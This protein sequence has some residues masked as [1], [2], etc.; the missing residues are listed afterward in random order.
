VLGVLAFGILAT[1]L[2]PLWL[3]LKLSTFSAGF[4]FFCLFPLSVN[5][6]EYRL[7]VSPTKRLLWNIPTHG[8]W[9]IKYIQAEG[10]RVASTATPAPTALPLKTD[11]EGAAQ[12]DYGFYNAHFEK[13]SGHL[14]ISTDSLR[15]VS[16]HPKV[17]HFTLPYDQIH[18]VEKVDR[19][20]AKNIPGKLVRD[21]GKDLKF[22][23][24]LGR[25]WLLRDVRQR[26]E[27]FSQ[28]IGF[29]RT[30]WQIVW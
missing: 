20:V 2:T 11:V 3:L 4:T 15:F 14:V 23:D 28:V 24:R 29:S 25:E 19:Q 5:Y 10:L 21:S 17:L 22:V 30:T 13:T 8:E 27:A 7:L 1:A 18:K 26:N 16:S 6:P 9:A 12:G